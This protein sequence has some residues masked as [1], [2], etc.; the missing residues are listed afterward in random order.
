MFPDTLHVD[1]NK[2]VSGKAF[3]YELR[4]MGLARSDRQVHVIEKAWE[5]CLSCRDFEHCYK[6]S[7]AKRSKQQSPRNSA[8]YLREETSS[9]P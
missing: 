9:L 7:M 1:I 6:L 2:V 4:S 5:D 8:H 3:S